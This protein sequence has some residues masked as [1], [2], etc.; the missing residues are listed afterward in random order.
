M[1]MSDLGDF[2]RKAVYW[3]IAFFFAAQAAQAVT[4]EVITPTGDNSLKIE[5]CTPDAIHVAC[6]KDRSFFPR[7]SLVLM[8][9]STFEAVVVSKT[10]TVDFSF[11]PT[12]DSTVRCR[13]K[14][15][16]VLL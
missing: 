11:T 8:P 14:T 12:T 1:H 10:N 5:A 15:I 16:E 3:L 2:R 6:A 9:R 13:G 4:R 7:L